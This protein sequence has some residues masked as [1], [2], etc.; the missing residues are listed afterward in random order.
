MITVMTYYPKYFSVC[1][2]VK[3]K[4]LTLLH[5]CLLILRPYSLLLIFLITTYSERNKSKTN[6]AFSCQVLL[7]SYCLEEVFIFCL[8]F[9]ILTH[10]KIT[11]SKL[12]LD[13]LSV[14]V[15]LLCPHGCI[16]ILHSFQECHLRNIIVLLP[17]LHQVA[18]GFDLS[19]YCS[20]SP[21]WLSRF[22][23][24]SISA[25]WDVTALCVSSV[26]FLYTEA[27]S[28]GE[29]NCFWVKMIVLVIIFTLI[30]YLR[31]FLQI[32]L[33][34]IFLFSILH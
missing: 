24:P 12:C 27:N 13:G 32:V 20:V 31:Y 26:L 6:F 8:T 19:Y 14:L 30:N 7:V 3:I 28:S 17:P 5:D 16:H 34:I 9:V 21:T 18:C 4:K 2:D 33:L 1:S 25:V 23:E 10:L 11:T 22:S 29:Q 15:W